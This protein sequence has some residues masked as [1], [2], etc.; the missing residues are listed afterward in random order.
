[1]DFKHQSRSKVISQDG[2]AFPAEAEEEHTT[3]LPPSILVVHKNDIIMLI[4]K[5]GSTTN[6]KT[7]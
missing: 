5:T 1:M 2:Q 4:Y 6:I 7:H 3:V